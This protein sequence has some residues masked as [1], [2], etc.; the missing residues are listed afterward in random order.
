MPPS[1]SYAEGEG[2]LV[3]REQDVS[4]KNW[5]VSN[6]VKKVDGSKASFA[7]ESGMPWSYFS[8][9]NPICVDNEVEFSFTLDKW[10]FVEGGWMGIKLSKAPETTDEAQY[11]SIGGDA[12]G[13]GA[14][15]YYMDQNVFA[16]ASADKQKWFECPV[17]ETVTFTL[18]KGETAW[19]FYI[20]DSWSQNQP[21][22]IFE[23]PYTTFGRRRL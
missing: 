16:T 11:G 12:N 13:V 18:K 6:G 3:V 4:L 7:I 14:F 15:M 20:T 22:W 17:G 2:E 10:A 8:Y 19:D 9:Q 23:V 21:F 1:W 5:N